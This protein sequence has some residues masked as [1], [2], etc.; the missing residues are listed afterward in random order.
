VGTNLTG[1]TSVNFSGDNITASGLVVNPTGTQLTANLNIE[2][3]AATG[4]RDVS[5]SVNTLVSNTL[6]GAF[7]VTAPAPYVPSGGGSSPVPPTV[8]SVS[9]LN[10]AT[11]VDIKSAVKA[12]FS[13]AMNA[14]TLNTTNFTLTKGTTAVAGTVTYD[15]TSKTAT[16]TPTAALDY[17]SLYTAT[18]TTGALSSTGYSL[19]SK[20]VWSFTT[21]AAPPPTTAPPTTAPPTTAPPTTAPPTTAPPTTVPPTTAPPTTKPVVTT[22]PVT[23]VS[24]T[25]TTPPP[26]KTN[27]GLIIGLIVAAVIIIAIVAILLSRRNRNKTH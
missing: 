15:S 17:A 4:V 3:A 14:N 9:P 18:I 11:G 12:V 26:G 27:W 19:N 23:T 2:S 6:T 25:T 22:T 10:S 16:F 7:T 8:S 13:L 5:V 1:A 24:P 21:V 20:Y